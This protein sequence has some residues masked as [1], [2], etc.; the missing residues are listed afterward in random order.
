MK[1]I[2]LLS[3][4]YPYRGGISQ[5]S[6][7]LANALSI[8]NSIFK[9]NYKRLY[10]SFLFP[11]KTQFVEYSQNKPYNISYGLDS[12]NPFSIFTVVSKLKSEPGQNFLLSVYWMSFFAP[13]LSLTNFFTPKRIKKVGIIHNLIPHE[14]RFFD[15]LFI[16]LF[17]SQQDAFVV[18][19][20]KVKSDLLTFKPNARVIKLFHPIYDHF[21][22]K[23]NK[24]KARKK[25]NIESDK[26]VLLFFGLI[27]DYKG[28]DVL[29]NALTLLDD[30]FILIIA[31]E[32]Y[33]GFEKYQTI[34]NNDNLSDRIIHIDNFI[35]D[36]EVPFLFSSADVCVLPY[37]DATQ[38]GVS[39]TAIHFETPIVCSK[40]GGLGEYV[41]DGKNGFLV[42]PN[43][44]A[45]LAKA[46]SIA[47]Q[48][49]VNLEMVQHTIKLKN[50]FSW[51]KFTSELNFF[52]ESL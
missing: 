33:G 1:K 14:P 44:H 49:E 8:R 50:S 20:E 22:E 29:L 31:G 32:C 26:K 28:L 23:E 2:H 43:N 37:K 41:K 9:I 48:A 21:G 17:L 11:G 7:A 39:A 46:I 35:S 27:R 19:S 15:S 45:E 38:S 51:D 34:I 5:F 52:L 24:I 40:I 10:P 36:E 30:D 25:Y 12:L 13:I 16:K 18:L 42:S 3:P 4:F 47:C 6:D